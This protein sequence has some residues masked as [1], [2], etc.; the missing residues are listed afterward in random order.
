MVGEAG[1]EPA[2]PCGQRILSPSCMPIPPLAHGG[3]CAGKENSIPC[4]TKIMEAAPGLEPGIKALQ[5][6]ALPTWRC[7]PKGL[8]SYETLAS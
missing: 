2:W 1:I 8:I 7:R 5:A 4:Q 3:G 6:S